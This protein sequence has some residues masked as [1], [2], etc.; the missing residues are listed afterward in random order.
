MVDEIILAILAVAPFELL[1]DGT[2]NTSSPGSL[3]QDDIIQYR[4]AQRKR[5]ED[6]QQPSSQAHGSSVLAINYVHLQQQERLRGGGGGGNSSSN[7]HDHASPKA[8]SVLE[9]LHGTVCLVPCL[10]AEEYDLERTTRHLSPVGPPV[11]CMPAGSCAV[12]GSVP[13]SGGLCDWEWAMSMQ[14]K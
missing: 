7:L 2:K 10:K 8:N 1:N 3:E 14:V 12:R 13:S 5:K 11:H 4:R 9:L 6:V